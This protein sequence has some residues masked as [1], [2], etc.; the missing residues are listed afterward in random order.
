MF[1]FSL[2]DTIAAALLGANTAKT[3]GPPNMADPNKGMVNTDVN[4]TRNTAG[5]LQGMKSAS[6]SQNSALEAKPDK[7]P[8]EYQ[9]SE[10]KLDA[11]A[12]PEKKEPTTKESKGFKAN[13]M[14]TVMKGFKGDSTVE[15]ANSKRDHGTPNEPIKEGPKERPTPPSMHNPK[16][17]TPPSPNIKATG[18]PD[19]K[20]KG[21]TRP[22]ART[23]KMNIP[24]F[25]G[26]KFK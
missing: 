2:K 6:E 15:G 3:P 25:R 20:M 16:L 23:P 8:L 22:Q 17:G 14:D 7:T 12:T 10:V 4:P 5:S 21:Y 1:N 19:S 24:Q 9:N 26:P 11:T 18:P 13:L